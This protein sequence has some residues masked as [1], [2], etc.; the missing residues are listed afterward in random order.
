MKRAR[1]FVKKNPQPDT[2]NDNESD[3]VVG[4]IY[5]LG[6]FITFII[7]M[8]ALTEEMNIFFAL[9]LAAIISFFWPVALIIFI[10]DKL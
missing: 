2:S 6:F 7:T 9:I 4:G 8:I 10:L 3:S 1:L 5:M